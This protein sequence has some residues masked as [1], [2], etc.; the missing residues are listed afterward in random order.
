MESE[1][2]LLGVVV[3]VLGVVGSIVVAWISTPRREDE[4]KEEPVR[5][6]TTIAGLAQVLTDQGHQISEL[7]R[8]QL[9]HEEHARVQDRTI[10]ALRRWALVLETALRSTGAT[11][12]EPTP[13]DAPLV[14]DGGQSLQL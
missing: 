1:P 14:R 3:A 5:D 12:P 11:V 8:K 7:Q 2:G 4:D 10:R 13:E 9:E 6:L